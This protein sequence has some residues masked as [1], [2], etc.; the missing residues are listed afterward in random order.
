MQTSET[1]ARPRR[2]FALG[3]SGWL[4]S[5]AICRTPKNVEKRAN[6]GN[7]CHWVAQLELREIVSKKFHWK[8][9][10]WSMKIWYL[11]GSGREERRA[12]TEMNLFQI[13]LWDRM[14]WAG[15]SAFQWR[16]ETAQVMLIILI[17]FILRHSALHLLSESSVSAFC[18]LFTSRF[19]H[20]R[21]NLKQLFEPVIHERGGEIHC[22]F[23]CTPY[24][25]LLL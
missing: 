20:S 19:Q 11:K 14:A 8:S 22:A 2:G 6:K 23:G 21:N 15:S 5:T 18:L 1:R 4:V 3:N 25:E 24:C 16:R 7:E 10:D 12:K 13:Q 9:N 17:F